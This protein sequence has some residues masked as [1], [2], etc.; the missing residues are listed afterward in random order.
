MDQKSFVSIAY[1]YFKRFP[2]LE[3]T[4]DYLPHP[5]LALVIVIPL[6]DE[7][8]VLPTLRSLFQEQ[9]SVFFHVEIIAVVNNAHNSSIDIKEQNMETYALLKEFALNHNNEILYFQF[10]LSLCRYIPT[11]FFSKVPRKLH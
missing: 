3:L 11:F 10:L 8:D 2:Y 9:D 4:F 7:K 5:D 1:N 6:F